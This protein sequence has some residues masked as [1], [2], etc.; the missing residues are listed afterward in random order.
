VL[1]RDGGSIL[2]KPSVE[3]G[4]HIIEAEEQGIG[5]S[6]LRRK[7]PSHAI[8]MDHA[9]REKANPSEG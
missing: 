2:R 5:V 9:L 3:A 1:H 6:D 4:H 8:G 7:I